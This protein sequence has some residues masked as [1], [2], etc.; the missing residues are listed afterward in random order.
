MPKV[1]TDIAEELWAR[2]D[3]GELHDWAQIKDELEP[4]ENHRVSYEGEEDAP[5]YETSD[6]DGDDDGDDGD[7]GPPRG[8][9]Q[10]QEA[11]RVNRCAT[12][13]TATT[14]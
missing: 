10:P 1:R 3:S 6:S 13:V 2:V 8:G 5:I 7:D 14:R 11:S 12:T 9:C 4:Q